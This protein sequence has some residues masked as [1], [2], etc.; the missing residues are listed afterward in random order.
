MEHVFEYIDQN[1][2]R[3]VQELLPLIA[4][5]SISATG[6]GIEDFASLMVEVIA[7]S[8][9]QAE[10][11]PVPGGP[12]CIY[13]EVSSSLSDKILMLIDHYDVVP[14]GR[15][16]D[17]DNPPFK[18]VIQNNRIW[19]RGAGDCKGQ[20]FTYLK[21]LEAW[22][23]VNGE[24]PVSVRMVLIGDDEIGA[25]SLDSLL[26]TH[27]ERLK[28]DAIF[29]ADASTLDV[30]GP[31]VILG[32]RGVLA[33][34]LVAHGAAYEAHSSSYGALLRNPAVRL[35]HAIAALRGEDGR[36]L[37][38]GF[39]DDLKPLGEVE[40]Y[41]LANL[42]VD[43]EAKLSSLGAAEFWG[44]P[45][46]EYFETQQYRPTF[47]IHGL[48]SGYTGEGWTAL[49]PTV[50]TAKIDINLV[51][52]LD[53]D[54]L[55]AKIRSH[56]DNCGFS[57]VEI[58][59]MTRNSYDTWAQPGD[60]FLEVVS[61]ALKR[62]WGV[63]PVLYPSIGGGG[64]GA[65]IFKD[66][67]GIENYA[68]VPLGQPDMNEHSPRESLDIDWFIRGIKVIATTIDEFA[69]SEIGREGGS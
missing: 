68:L 10:L 47:N 4:Q 7:E 11:L 61:R 12:P 54:D 38:P 66:L 21:A 23:A 57:D 25:P 14:P 22:H 9:F 58:Q 28:A 69:K 41:L 50:A 43:R 55:L 32:L 48:V 49:V 30:W 33:I 36:I 6:E 35:A 44:D 46:Y 39:Y 13:C 19:G 3:F 1:R 65:V 24:L 34:N 16:E 42:K 15:L 62:V 45:G 20:F 37:V 56:L 8:G 64:P 60:L 52:N 2:D 5:P 26:K 29:C 59:E 27:T 63:E 53:P 51:P 31:V 40:R 18:P 67:V 17:W